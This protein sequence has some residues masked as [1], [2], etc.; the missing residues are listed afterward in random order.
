MERYTLLMSKDEKESAQKIEKNCQEGLTRNK[1]ECVPEAK[2][3]FNRDIQNKQA[4][5]FNRNR[6]EYK[7]ID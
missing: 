2:G 4:Q 3:F 7:L 1:R 6:S 5:I